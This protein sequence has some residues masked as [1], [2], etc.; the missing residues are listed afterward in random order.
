MYQNYLFDLYGTLVDIHTN[1]RKPYLWEK[2]SE[3]YAFQSAPYAPKELKAAYHAEAAKEKEQTKKTHPAFK[4]ID[5]RLEHVFARLYQNKGVSVS[6]ELALYTAQAFRAI[7]TKYIRLYP[8]ARELLSGLK[9]NGRR[10]YLLT[11][12]Q[13]CFTVPELRLLDIYSLF[14]GIVISS[15]EYTCKPDKAFYETILSRYALKQNETIMIGNDYIT[16]IRGSFE[17]G[18]DSLYIHSNLSPEVEGK[19][20]SKYSVM[21]GDVGRIGEHIL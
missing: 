21:D 10:V 1:E 8:G 15:D 18:L 5:I 17:A 20:L 2:M 13:R 12:A 7:S 3:L 6:E 16:D 9:A 19:L 4:H 14:D 11:N